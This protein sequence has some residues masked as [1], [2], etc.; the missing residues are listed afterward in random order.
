[1]SSGP[2]TTTGSFFALFFDYDISLQAILIG[3]DLFPHALLP[4]LQ[5]QCQQMLHDWVAF[6]A[7]MVKTLGAMDAEMIERNDDAFRE[8]MITSVL[9]GAAQSMDDLRRVRSPWPLGLSDTSRVPTLIFR[10]AGDQLIPLAATQYLQRRFV[11][12][13]TMIE[14]PDMGH[15]PA[16]SHYERVFAAVRKLHVHEEKRLSGAGN[17]P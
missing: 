17:R 5:R 10:G 1:M 14:F 4:E 9:Q 13:A 3:L 16:L 2:P 7:D 12:N 6:K 15:Q 11:P 8:N